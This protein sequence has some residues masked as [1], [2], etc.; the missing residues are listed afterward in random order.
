[1]FLST[2][3]TLSPGDAGEQVLELQRRLTQRDL[4]GEA[5]QTGS[6][7]DPTT[8]AVMQFQTMQGLRSDGIAGPLTL[9]A[10]ASF[11]NLAGGGGEGSSGSEAEEEKELEQREMADRYAHLHHEQQQEAALHSAWGYGEAM[12]QTALAA[13]PEPVEPEVV[14]AKQATR[15]ERPMEQEA[16]A[17]TA[18]AAEKDQLT[19]SKEG[20]EARH[21]MDELN[22]K[23]LVE[24]PREAPPEQQKEAPRNPQPTQEN[25]LQAEKSAA[26]QAAA[27]SPERA[28]PTQQ[29][30][31]ATPPIPGEQQG[32]PA[33]QTP[34]DPALAQTEAKLDA[35]SKTQTQ[36]EGRKLEA[37]GVKQGEK[38]PESELGELSP[39]R[40]PAVA[41]TQEVGRGA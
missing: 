19:F 21:V 25:A 27:A 31:A 26:Q 8:T 29:T 9:R 3:I 6:Y 10:L 23:Q 33:P 11:G 34:R 22:D 20:V 32:A 17:A 40:T 35:G 24:K 13:K 18:R 12:E 36:E 14:Q 37:K 1:M 7:D 4:L 2:D 38:V 41:R 30:A 39:A 16:A 28:A 15:A 5:N